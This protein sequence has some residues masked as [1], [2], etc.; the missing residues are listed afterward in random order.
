MEFALILRELTRHRR[1]LA[2]GV[3]IAAIAAVHSVY[4]LEG[5]KL[6]PKSLQHSSASTQVLVDWE[7]SVVGNV[8]QPTEPLVS[9]AQLFEN[10]MT[11]PAVLNLIG[12]QVG[13]SGEQL[14]AQGPV[15]ANVQRVEQE[16]TALRRNVEITGETKP[17]RLNFES[18]AL[19]PTITINSQAPTTTQAVA[20][21]NATAVAMQRYVA[22]I[23]TAN[24]VPSSS[25]VVIRQLGPASGAVVDVGIRKSL[26]AMTFIAVFV[27]WCVLVLVASRFRESWRASAALQGARE[28]GGA[29][30]DN[31]QRAPLAR[32]DTAA[33]ARNGQPIPPAPDVP[34][35][36]VPAA[37]PDSPL[38]DVPLPDPDRSHGGVGAEHAMSTSQPAG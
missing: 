37:A 38:L 23:E 8:Q 31:T 20:L 3:L 9:R 4:R 26:A 34:P 1:A 16:P 28:Q 10:F 6:K 18:A 21:A 30:A 12:R 19:Q 17:Y 24:H 14:Y 13:L 7:S 35:W 36:D 32:E 11:S 22:G 33:N 27:L 29:G 25:R 5:F 2:I 15:I